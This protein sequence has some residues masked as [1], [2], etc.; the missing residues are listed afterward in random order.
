[1]PARGLVKGMW[2]RRRR[3]A[4]G[5]IA[6]GA[7]LVVV[8]ASAGGSAAGAPQ[9]R[10]GP[11]P[12]SVKGLAPSL[13][14]ISRAAQSS[15]TIAAA[16]LAGTTGADVTADGLRVIVEP[17]AGD[18]AA[19]TI[20]VEAHGCVVERTAEGLVQALVPVGDLEA[21]GADPAVSLVRQSYP[22]VPETIVTGE[23]IAAMNAAGYTSAGYDGT[24]VKIGII[25]SGF[26][27]YASK[28]GTELPAS[29]TTKDFCGGKLT[30]QTEHGTAVAEIVHEVAPG[31][32]LYLICIDTD[33]DLA[34]AEAYAKAQG[35]KIVNHSVSWFNSSRGDGSG[36]GTAPDA[37]VADAKSHGIL[38]VNAAGNQAENHWSGNYVDDGQDDNVFSGSDIFDRFTIENAATACATLKWDS[39]PTTTTDYDLYIVRMSDFSIVAGIG[40]EGEQYPNGAPPVENTCYTNLDPTQTFA[41][42]IVRYHA[43]SEPRFDLYVLGTAPI[44]YE[45][46]AG[47]VTEPASSPNAL[48]VGALCWSGF[49]LEPYSSRGPNIAGVTKPDMAG[50]DYVSSSVYGPFSS[51]TGDLGFAGTSASAPG[52]AGAAALLLQQNPALTPTMLQAMIQ[53]NAVDLGTAGMDNLYGS[54]RL[55]LPTLPANTVAPTISGAT[56]V[57]A[58]LTAHTGAW[59]GAPS[60][61]SY[62]WRSCDPLGANCADLVG[63]NASSHVITSADVG[64]TLRVAVTGTNSSGSSVATSDATGIP[65]LPSNVTAPSISGTAQTGSILT[66]APGSWLGYPAPTFAYV[67]ERC[68]ASGALCSDIVPAVT[69]LTYV[70]GVADL[71]QTLRVKVTASNG[72]GPV[73]PI[74][75]AQ[76]PVITAPSSGGGGGGGGGGSG[77]SD[78]VATIS[79]PATAKI[80]DSFTYAITARD[81]GTGGSDN[82]IATIT[83]PAGV[84]LGAV[85]FDRGAGCTGTTVLTCK[86]DFLNGG[87]VAHVNLSVNVTANG[88]QVATVALTSSRPDINPANNTAT[89]T[90]LVGTSTPPPPPGNGGGGARPAP[91]LTRTGTTTVKPVHL[92]TTTTVGFGVKLNRAASVTMTVKVKGGT[93]S[94]LLL[95]GSKVGSKT[96]TKGATSLT[97]SRAAGSFAVKA[98]VGKNAFVKGTSYLV[99]VVAKAPDGRKSTLTVTFKG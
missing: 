20:A 86:L 49:G 13:Q 64:H 82:V 84:T 78:L 61:F 22:H 98:L 79:A 5:A 43:S 23:E 53:A 92:R 46:P 45:T 95:A 29:V 52:I 44:Q 94:M 38:W 24:G 9:P 41:V 72:G 55:V 54:G 48:A 7:L 25:D 10:P 62:Q 16:K 11:R 83:L 63:Q 76:T 47:S 85:S 68:D 40:T 51:C 15:G 31:A 58:T 8:Q 42:K 74:A 80:G 71:G 6:A 91:K 33:V 89:A 97:A 60:S 57:G 37:T 67:W 17:R 35:I 77:T 50:Y 99:T 65:G 32:Q 87:L 69:S 56:S 36:T 14:E 88:S 30:T 2:G 39:W 34:S 28:L 4:M 70:P 66:A 81:L 12:A 27:G 1:M 90:T 21:L 75:S 59:N 3:I 93:R 96:S 19:T 18:A 26:V 73:G